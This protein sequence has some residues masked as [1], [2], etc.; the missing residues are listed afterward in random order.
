[1]DGPSTKKQ[2]TKQEKRFKCRGTCESTKP[3]SW[4]PTDVDSKK[5]ICAHCIVKAAPR[6]CRNCEEQKDAGKFPEDRLP[7]LVSSAAYENKSISELQEEVL[8]GYQPICLDCEPLVKAKH[9]EAMK[10]HNVQF[11][12]WHNAVWSG[13]GKNAIPEIQYTETKPEAL[14]GV[15]DIIFHHGTCV[16]EEI[17]NRTTKGTVTLTEDGEGKVTGVVE[18]LEEL[19]MSE[20]LFFQ[21][22]FELTSTGTDDHGGYHSG[23]RMI[24]D[25][26]LTD[27]RARKVVHEEQLD[28]EPA[29]S[30]LLCVKERSS[31]CGWIKNEH[32][33][34]ENEDEDKVT[35]KTLEEAEALDQAYQ[36]GPKTEKPPPVFFVEPG[37]LVLETNWS[38]DE[39][40]EPMETT[41]VLRK[42]VE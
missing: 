26:M 1:M 15:Y 35:F 24:C 23:W 20:V 34:E 8:N 19:C 28:G 30:E 40:R 13:H 22:D 17:E 16:G 5:R 29:E 39:W 27:E 10:T 36:N 4:F 3:E 32:G 18:F 11:Y 2:K 31:A 14:A 21:R 12:D 25:A 9:E 33:G 38:D 41:C 6:Q 7:G 37:D 42:R